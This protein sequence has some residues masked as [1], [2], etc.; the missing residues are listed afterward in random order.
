VSTPPTTPSTTPP[1]TPGGNG[2]GNGGGNGNGNG[3]GGTPGSS[4][5][6]GGD[7]VSLLD[8]FSRHGENMAQ[9]RVNKSVYTVAEKEHF[10]QHYELVS[11][12]GRCAGFLYGDSPFT[13]CATSHK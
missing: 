8:V 11:I 6:I 12:A 2:N 7:N 5:T 3:G 4:T 1:T 10:H 13:L 9:V